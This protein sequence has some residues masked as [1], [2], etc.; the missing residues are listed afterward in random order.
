MISPVQP[1]GDPKDLDDV[2]RRKGVLV[3]P[4]G[5]IPSPP[6]NP[7]PPGYRRWKTLGT[8]LATWVIAIS[9]VNHDG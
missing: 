4:H 6:L 1:K 7:N 3:R 8:S 5:A 2:Y 9:L